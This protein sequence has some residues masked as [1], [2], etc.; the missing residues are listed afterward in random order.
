MDSDSCTREQSKEKDNQ[1]TSDGPKQEG[2]SRNGKSD[3]GNIFLSAR[4]RRAFFK[5][6]ETNKFLLDYGLCFLFP[7]C[8]IIYPIFFLFS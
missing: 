8:I 1:E 4:I 3:G 5:H 2:I 6:N 7:V